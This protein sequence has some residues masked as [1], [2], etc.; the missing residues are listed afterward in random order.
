MN[1]VFENFLSDIRPYRSGGES[2]GTMAFAPRVELTDNGQEYLVHCELPGCKK[3]DISLD[4]HDQVLAI[5]GETKF[6]QEVN[7]ENVKFSERRYGK[8]SRTIPL[9]HRVAKDKVT[10]KFEDGVL[11]VVLPRTEEEQKKRIT[12][13]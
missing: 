13:S 9:P 6:K 4:V 7:R 11:E 1:R 8:W 10:A 12:I 5:Q 2:G 3:E